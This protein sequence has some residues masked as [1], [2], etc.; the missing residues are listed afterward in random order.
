MLQ[1]KKFKKIMN[2]FSATNT[3]SI[4]EFKPIDGWLTAEAYLYRYTNTENQKIY[5]GI[6][7]HGEKAYFH[8]STDEELIMA[9][10]GSKPILIPVS[11]THLTLPTKR[12]V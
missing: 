10:Q 9:T 5:V 4:L 11:Y 12:I 6:H 3:K 2:I 8:S 1:F 7:K